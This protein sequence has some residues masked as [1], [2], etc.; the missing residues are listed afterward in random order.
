MRILDKVRR[1]ILYLQATQIIWK[2]NKLYYQVDYKKQK[3]LNKKEGASHLNAKQTSKKRMDKR[4]DTSLVESKKN[5][6]EFY[7]VLIK[8]HTFHI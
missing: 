4:S 1:V 7:V 8:Y 5:I 6:K 2:S 3:T